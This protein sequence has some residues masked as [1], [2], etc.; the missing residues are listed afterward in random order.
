M[1]E[2]WRP[3]PQGSVPRDPK[4]LRDGIDGE[5]LAETDSSVPILQRTCHGADCD[6]AGKGGCGVSQTQLIRE[7]FPPEY[8]LPLGAVLRKTVVC[9][10]VCWTL[11]CMCMCVL[12]YV[13]M[14]VHVHTSVCLHVYTSVCV[15]VGAVAC[16]CHLLHSFE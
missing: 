7:S 14:G 16:C 13:Y 12:I 3:E 4:G 5:T 8:P 6:S 11:I 2:S 1:H 15:G 9:S 10:G